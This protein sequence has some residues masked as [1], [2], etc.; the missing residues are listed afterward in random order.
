VWSSA[1][2]PLLALL[3]S[4]SV[5]LN[6]VKKSVGQESAAISPHEIMKQIY[7]A[8][9]T[10]PW[11]PSHRVV[12]KPLPA[13]LTS[14][15]HIS[16]VYNSLDRARRKSF[17]RAIKPLRRLLRNQGAVNDS[18]IDALFHLSAQTQEMVEEIRDLRR[19]LAALQKQ[20]PTASSKP[21]DAGPIAP[22]P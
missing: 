6:Q 3:R 9:S 7:D 20:T 5:R 4:D 10:D 12:T 2:L 17:V 11:R 13:S 15:A 16:H 21:V 22:G 14:D 18:L 19:Q 8:A 1:L